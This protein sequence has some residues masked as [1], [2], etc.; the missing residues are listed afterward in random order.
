MAKQRMS[1][2]D[3][4]EK[5]CCTGTDAE[6]PVRPTCDLGS[7]EDHAWLAQWKAAFAAGSDRLRIGTERFREDAREGAI[8]VWAYEYAERIDPSAKSYPAT[9]GTSRKQ[10]PPEFFEE[11]VDYTV[12]DPITLRTKKF[13]IFTPAWRDPVVRFE[14][15]DCRPPAGRPASTAALRRWIEGTTATNI[16]KGQKEAMEYFGQL[17]LKVPREPFRK[18]WSEVTDGRGPGR[19]PK[20]RET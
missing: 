2:P 7:V 17:G 16:N 11:E 9:H 3:Y 6:Y 15:E 19:P 20:E 13:H 8:A 18:I 1:L 5:F 14:A 4:I 10:I 12:A